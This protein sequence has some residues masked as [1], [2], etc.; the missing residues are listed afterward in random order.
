MNNVFLR[1]FLLEFKYQFVD[2]GLSLRLICMELLFVCYFEVL[3]SLDLYHHLPLPS[4]YWIDESH[5]TCQ[6]LLR[7][8]KMMS[9]FKAPLFP[10][11]LAAVHLMQ[12]KVVMALL[13]RP[14]R[15]R[16]G[17]FQGI[18][19]SKRSTCLL[20]VHS[21]KNWLGKYTRSIFSTTYVHDM[22]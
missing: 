11:L 8:S 7:N 1:E 10:S 4:L 2:Q 22:N 14:H 16:K 12:K 18:Q 6:T 3:P 9:S 21:S 15:K 20:Y 19:A 5:Q 13:H 17:I